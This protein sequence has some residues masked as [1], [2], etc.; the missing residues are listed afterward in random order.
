MTDLIPVERT[1]VDRDPLRIERVLRARHRA[2]QLLTDPESIRPFRVAGMH[3]VTVRL[4]EPAPPVSWSA[5]NPTLSAMTKAL[6]FGLAVVAVPGA[7]VVL[8]VTL[9]VHAVGAGTLVGGGFVI[10]ALALALSRSGSRAHS[11]HKGE[12]FHWSKCK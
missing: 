6:A 9:V 1:I 7:L 11:G 12:G 5:R 10:L 2:G 3:A 8:A 4:L